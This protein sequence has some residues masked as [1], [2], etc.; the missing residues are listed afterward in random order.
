MEMH[1]LYLKRQYRHDQQ[2]MELEYVLVLDLL[3]D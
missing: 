2:G 1:P 3:S